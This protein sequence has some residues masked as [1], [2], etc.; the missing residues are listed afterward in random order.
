MAKKPSLKKSVQTIAASHRLDQVVLLAWRARD[1]R[2]LM[3][4]SGLNKI[5][6]AEAKRFAR[7]WKRKLGVPVLTKTET[8]P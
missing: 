7:R 8:M 5:E 3:V 1:E 6:T 2:Y 4:A